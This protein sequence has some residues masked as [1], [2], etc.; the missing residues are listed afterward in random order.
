MK[1]S[2]IV[3]VYNEK[4][5]IIDCIERVQAIVL[6]R[7]FEKEII[8][9]DDGSTDGTSE[10]FE[11]CPE[12]PA[13]TSLRGI[14]IPEI[15]I[16]Y[17]PRNIAEGKKI[18]WYDGLGAI[19]TLVF[20]RFKRNPYFYIFL[21]AIIVR[22]ALFFFNL[23]GADGNLIT[24][25][26]GQD[27]YFD[28]SRNLF[29]GNGFSINPEPPYFE[30]SYGV[31]GYPY[32]LYFLL[33]LSGGS[34]AFTIAVQMILGAFIPVIGMHLTHLL[35]PFRRAPLIVGILL[36]LAPYQ[37]LFSFIFYT[38]TI[39]TFLFGIF[40]ILFFKFLEHLSL[41]LAVW[42]SMFLAL[43]ALTRPVVQYYVILVP[44][45]MLWHFRKGITKNL[46]KKIALFVALFFLVLSP[47]LYRNH[48][49][50]NMI[51][52]SGQ[53]PFNLYQVLLPSVLSMANG[54]S[55]V[56]EQ[57]KL[58]RKAADIFFNTPKS[59]SSEAINEIKKHPIALIKLSAL[60]GFT[61]FTHDG[62]L[63]FLQASGIQPVSY[64]SKPAVIMFLTE[65]VQLMREIWKQLHTSFALVFF[66]RLF[67]VAV[68][69]LFLLGIY[70]LWRWHLLT[71]A[72]IFAVLT[73]FYFMFTT[74]ING[75]TVNARFRMPV[76]PLIFIIA[77]AGLIFLYQIFKRRFAID[78]IKN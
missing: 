15:P 13:L 44:L 75:L 30:Y 41:R 72:I 39:F 47:W 12:V 57:Q 40:L 8:I 70:A 31:P 63:T 66:A 29:F 60:N 22:L 26:H 9:V 28:L 34:Y 7:G 77:Y 42:S 14:K 68:M 43:S 78:N 48:R 45:F 67:W 62:M 76:E 11:Y 24:I 17:K 32:F 74:M 5:T 69:A 35:V 64:L 52:L 54:T 53:M 3:P 55:F 61:F 1:L 46:V 59:V 71:G 18:R 56:L 16:S 37:I 38:E 33:W 23:N 10:P 20:H 27:G 58:P 50:F 51:A 4:N 36:A 25:I 21:L 73:V 19:K 2:I 65:P 6:P 49:T